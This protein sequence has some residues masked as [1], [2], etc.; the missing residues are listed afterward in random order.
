MSTKQLLH[1]AE[2]I[3]E[4]LTEAHEHCGCSTNPHKTTAAQVGA[5]CHGEIRTTLGCSCRTN[6]L[7][8]GCASRDY[9]GVTCTVNADGSITLNGTNTNSIAY[10]VYYTNMRTGATDTAGQYDNYQLLPPG[11]YIAS[12]GIEGKTDFQLCLSDTEN[13]L[14]TNLNL[15]AGGRFTVPEGKPY[16]LVRF[17]I[18]QGSEFNNETVYP[19][20]RCADVEDDTYQPYQPTIEERLAKLEA[21][22]AAMAATE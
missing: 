10:G 6:W 19:M 2:E 1:T 15:G 7:Q 17:R 14:G 11:D 20:I 18:A 22:Y 8:N 21:L 16:V 4:Q 5:P 3:D 9:A 13:T 12:G